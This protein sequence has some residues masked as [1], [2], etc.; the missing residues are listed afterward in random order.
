MLLGR[1]EDLGRRRQVVVVVE[2]EVTLVEEV[3]ETFVEMVVEV[4]SVEE[5]RMD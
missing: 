5:V 3:V 2:V 4:T 1:M